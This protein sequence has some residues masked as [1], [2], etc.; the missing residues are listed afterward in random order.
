MC[1]RSLESNVP[2][3]VSSPADRVLELLDLSPIALYLS[4]ERIKGFEN[5]K[6][7]AIDTSPLSNYVMHP[8]W[9]LVVKLV[10]TW[11]AP[12]V[13]TFTGFLLT[14]LNAILLSVYDYNFCASSDSVQNIPP[15]PK[16][17]CQTSK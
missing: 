9:N 8:F 2:F 6:Y 5:Y 7:S 3:R 17:V 10:P 12:N 11:L 13:L 14:L 1:C 16:W 15:V 4:P